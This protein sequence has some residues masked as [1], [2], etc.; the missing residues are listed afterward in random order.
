MTNYS[1]KSQN[2]KKKNTLQIYIAQEQQ[3]SKIMR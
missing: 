1:A 3:M 2:K